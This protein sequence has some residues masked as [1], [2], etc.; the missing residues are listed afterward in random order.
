M[1]LLTRR[2]ADLRLCSTIRA[3]AACCYSTAVDAAS[4]SERKAMWKRTSKSST[5]VDSLSVQVKG[6]QGGDGCIS[7]SRAKY[8]PYGPPS[9]AS[10]GRGGDIYIEASR[11]I[12]SLART[13]N[14]YIAERGEHGTGEWQGGK[15]GKDRIIRVPVGTVVSVQIVPPEE[16]MEEKATT[17][18]SAL[19]KKYRNA[20]LR[21]RRI[22]PRSLPEAST[23][24][25]AAD[26]PEA[27]EQRDAVWRHYPGGTIGQADRD[28]AE[29][30]DTNDLS[31]EEKAE[32]EDM[33]E[34][35]SD[36][37]GTMDTFRES[38]KRYAFTLL[39]EEMHAKR[40][41]SSRNV[42]WGLQE[43]LETGY[44]SVDLIEE[45]STP[46]LVASGGAGGLGNA[47]FLSSSNKSPKLATR[48]AAGQK[49]IVNLEWKFKG[50]VGLIGLPNAGKSTFLK[51]VCETGEDVR[52]ASYAFTTLTPNVGVVRLGEE[53]LIG[54][55]N[56]VSIEES[57][58]RKLVASGDE[59]VQQSSRTKDGDE[60]ARFT[61][62]DLPGLV[63]GASFNRGLGHS[64]LKHVERCLALYHVVD[65]NH[66]PWQDL[67]LVHEELESYQ[68]GLSLKVCG[69]IANK[70]DLLDQSQR[71]KL[72]LLKV[73][74]TEL[75]GDQIRVYNVS[76]KH[77]Q[78]VERVAR[79]MAKAV[80]KAQRKDE[81]LHEHL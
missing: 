65:V 73:K 21:E 79:E 41:E 60:T 44:W 18:R 2:L 28:Q 9:G 80:E 35:N 16:E 11:T 7:F 62:Q 81:T 50:D 14:S 67:F 13:S 51:S 39:T 58:K 6:G 42:Q 48:G 53:G 5:F 66:Q 68:A 59:T 29:I 57:G 25:F 30:D 77:R 33:L 20:F 47:F 78:G 32:Q 40:E 45:S 15:K 31:E 69:V 3:R 23:E 19:K 24:S 71:E 75:Y 4:S 55:R 12:A 63:E 34:S 46:L 26:P 22:S 43:E 38:E 36:I 17:Y 74:A 61:L 70:C 37:V 72:R 52:V 76:A 1:L 64:F 8:V 10:G 49:A 56:D 54:V 27:R